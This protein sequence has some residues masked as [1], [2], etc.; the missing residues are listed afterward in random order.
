MIYTITLA[1]AIEQLIVRSA[2]KRVPAPGQ[3]G[4]PAQLARNPSARVSVLRLSQYWHVFEMNNG[5][6][7][8]VNPPYESLPLIRWRAHHEAVE[9]RL[10]LD[11]TGEA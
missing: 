2:G 6:L 5:G 9:R 11:L 4:A 1:V 7:R 10:D 3:D 8:F